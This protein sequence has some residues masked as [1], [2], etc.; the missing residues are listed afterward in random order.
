MIQPVGALSPRATFRGLNETYGKRPSY[1]RT[2]ANIAL[3]NA[4]GVALAAGGLTTA[5]AR[6]YTPNWAY[7]GV[8]GLFGSLLSLFFMTPQI[9]ENRGNQ[10][11]IKKTDSDKFLKD[12]AVKTAET[13][14]TKLTPAKKMVQ[15]R[16][17]E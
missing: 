8:L 12:E 11:A 9:I 5:I 2:K 4:G 6:S 16:Q 7:A 3:V 10:S 15:F 14:K 13:V 17:G 1:D